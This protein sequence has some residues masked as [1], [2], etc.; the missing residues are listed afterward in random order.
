MS[1]AS[2][3]SS[4]TLGYATVGLTPDAGTTWLLPRAVGFQKARELIV[5]NRTVPADEALSIGLISHVVDDADFAEFL[6]EKAAALARK[7]TAHLGITRQL[8]ADGYTASYEEQL[9][10]ERDS[11]AS[12]SSSVETQY[13][14]RKFLAKT[15][16]RPLQH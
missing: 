12:A 6:S 7:A 1:I 14:I 5:T 13:L 15:R 8:I 9:S 10:S 2:R 11:I 16:E 3:S 4:F